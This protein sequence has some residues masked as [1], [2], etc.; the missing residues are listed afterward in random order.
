MSKIG[1]YG[2]SFNPPTKAHIEL[3][4]KVI[5]ECSLDKVIFVPVGDLYEKEGM[6]K[7][8]HRY[9]MLEIASNREVNL[10]VSDIE[11]RETKNYKTIEIFEIL[12]NEY[13]KE[14][15]YFIMGA[16]NLQKLPFWHESNKLV[17]DYNYIILD[18]GLT[19]TKDIIEN[20]ELLKKNEKR[21]TII[22][23]IEFY[24]CSSTTIREQ[25]KKGENPENLDDGVYSYIREN[26]IYSTRI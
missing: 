7:A 20:N 18:R 4:K 22:S 9:N 1:F 6:A 19:K 23:N 8:I 10:Q 14:E 16:D 24:D 5:K 25:I 21:F 2:G 11:I 3:A 13:R 12:K 17:S 15:I 26:N